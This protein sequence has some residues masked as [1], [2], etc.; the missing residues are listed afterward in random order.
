MKA[1]PRFI[2]QPLSFWGY[3]K[4][5]STTIGYSKNKS[6]LKYSLTEC[7]NALVVNEISITQPE[8]YQVV[9]YLNYRSDILNNTV[10]NYFMTAPEAESLYKD[11]TSQIDNIDEYICPLPMNKQKNEKKNLAFFTCIINVL[12]E[13]TVRSFANNTGI[14]IPV[15]YDPRNLAYFTSNYNTLYST[16]SR[17]YD[18]IVPSLCNPIALWE[19]KEYYYTTTFGSRIADGVYETQ[20]DGYEVNSLPF[21]VRPKHYYFIDGY[22]TWWDDGKSYL[23]RIID[24]LHQQQ[25][26]EVF[27]GREVVSEWTRSLYGLLCTKYASNTS[28]SQSI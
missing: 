22:K 24:M 17:R 18:G 14:S 27:F 15:D 20:L 1:D 28:F 19:I 5:L 4:F 11:I 23:C 7:A 10:K 8:L 3:V 26:D 13:L 6:L 25:V 9:S 21:E 12:T 16:F 2:N